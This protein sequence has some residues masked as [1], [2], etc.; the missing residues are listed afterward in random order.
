MAMDGN[1]EIVNTV[2]FR[3]PV[4]SPRPSWAEIACFVKQLDGNVLDIESTYRTAQE[5][6]LFIKF[7]SREAMTESLKK[8]SERRV[9]QYT[10][11]KNVEVQMT[12]AG[13]NMHYVRVFDLPPE[14]ND[15]KLSLA[16]GEYG[17]VERLVRE[18]FPADL[19]LGHV[20]TGV[21]GAYMDVK[22]EIPPAVFVGNRKGHVFYDGLK[23]TCFLCKAVGHRKD[24]CPLRQSQYNQKRPGSYADVVAG[25]PI[26]SGEQEL[27]E[28]PEVIEIIEE[29]IIEETAETTDAEE[30][31]EP[32]ETKNEREREERRKEG[33]ETLKE[34]AN[35][36][37][38]AIGKQQA[39]Q[40]RAQFASSGSK[41]HSRPK[42]LC[43]R[44][45][46]Y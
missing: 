10:N 8:N 43:A 31:E 30:Q 42:K 37:S 16:L 29:D 2:Q 12:I 32:I 41:E 3:F 28:V 39:S 20:Y 5:R 38:E 33:I 35:A 24:S 23:D 19:G 46:L 27:F 13:S 11:G 9:F 6:S 44:K 26:V 14:V 25:P 4:A 17:K 40:R 36:I 34:V 22:K 45:S 15:E 21:R 18:K 1:D 7:V